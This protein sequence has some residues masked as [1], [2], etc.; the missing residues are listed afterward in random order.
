MENIGLCMHPETG[1]MPHFCLCAGLGKNKM[2]QVGKTLKKQNVLLGDVQCVW[3][4]TKQR[5]FGLCTSCTSCTCVFVTVEQ[6]HS[7]FLPK[8]WT[9]LTVY[10]IQQ[11]TINA[12]CT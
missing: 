7:C 5:L 9:P 1:L 10:R 12:N 3:N 2:V 11:P 6:H 8:D 4:P